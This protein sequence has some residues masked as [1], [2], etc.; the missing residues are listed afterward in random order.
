MKNALKERDEN[1]NAWF[2][3]D[4]IYGV[5][6]NIS[7]A[8]IDTYLSLSVRLSLSIF[9]SLCVCDHTH[10]RKRLTILNIKSISYLKSNG[11]LPLHSIFNNKGNSSI[12]HQYPCEKIGTTEIIAERSRQ[13][14]WT[15][16]G[17]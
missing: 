13:C 5:L 7:G 3:D 12:R 4:N 17:T 14:H 15:E 9:L 16:P 1:G 2:N 11:M 8:G 6:Y 10:V